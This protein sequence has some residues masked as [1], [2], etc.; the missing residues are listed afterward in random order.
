MRLEGTLTDSRSH[1]TF[2]PSLRKLVQSNSE[3]FIQETIA[4]AFS[5]EDSTAGKL[6]T[7]VKLKGIGPATASLLLSTL[8]PKGTPFFSDELFR[9]ACYEDKS[10]FRWDRKIKYSAKEYA[11]LLEK[12]TGLRERLD[13]VSAVDV[14]KVAYE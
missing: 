8:D 4:A 14:E 11:E 2:R 1:G 6:N 9:W 13:G 12:V 7:L 10:G 5:S 3:E